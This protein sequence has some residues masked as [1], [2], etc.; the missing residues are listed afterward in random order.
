MFS[1]IHFGVRKAVLENVFRRSK[2]TSEKKYTVLMGRFLVF[3]LLMVYTVLHCCLLKPVLSGET[4]KL[5]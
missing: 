4:Y 3:A 1:E 2:M 5:K